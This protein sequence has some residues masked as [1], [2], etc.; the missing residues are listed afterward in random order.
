MSDPILTE[1]ERD[2]IIKEIKGICQEIGCTGIDKSCIESPQNCKII[3]KLY[4]YV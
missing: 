4:L 3:R 1:K 2:G